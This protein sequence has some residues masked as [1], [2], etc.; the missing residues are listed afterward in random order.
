MALAR[1]LSRTKKR[2]FH[3]FDTLLFEN[4]L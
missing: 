3:L 4:R 1:L 2:A